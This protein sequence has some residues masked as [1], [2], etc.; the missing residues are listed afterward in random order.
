M[1]S[2]DSS[3]FTGYADIK[4][5]VDAINSG[6]LYRYI[7]KPWDPD[8]LIELLHDAAARY[9]AVVERQRLMSD[10][11]DYVRRG[12]ELVNALREQEAVERLAAD[13]LAHLAQTGGQLLQRLDRA[14]EDDRTKGEGD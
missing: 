9:D 1:R 7:T 14:L 5:V 3:S 12:Q 13:E 4:A 10:L 6:G 11:Q 2:S 8:E